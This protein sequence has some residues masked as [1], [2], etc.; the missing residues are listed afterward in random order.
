MEV[1]KEKEKFTLTTEEQ[2]IISRRN[3]PTYPIEKA[4]ILMQL[5]NNTKDRIA[6]R[7]LSGM[8]Q[9]AGKNELVYRRE[10]VLATLHAME[11]VLRPY[12]DQQ[13]EEELQRLLTDNGG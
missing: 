6:D 11:A 3:E 5:V 4:D 12:V 9:G 13:I 2:I 1:D 7:D 10:K 8:P